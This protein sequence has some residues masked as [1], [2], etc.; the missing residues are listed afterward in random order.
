MISNNNNNSNSD[1]TTT[2]IKQKYNNDIIL[3]IMD[4]ISNNSKSKNA[5]Y[6]VNHDY[7]VHYNT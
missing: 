6:I 3:T 7:S 5:N 4:E 2:T 1:A